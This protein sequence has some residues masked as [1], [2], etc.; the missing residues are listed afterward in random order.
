[1]KKLPPKERPTWC[2][3]RRLSWEELLSSTD[4]PLWL[5]MKG[6][7]HLN[8]W[9]LVDIAE[10]TGKVTLLTRKWACDVQDKYGEGY[11]CYSPIPI[12]NSGQK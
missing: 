4:V 1:M 3:L 8:Q 7:E 10:S 11:W 12:K 9:C 2:T 6:F 5:E